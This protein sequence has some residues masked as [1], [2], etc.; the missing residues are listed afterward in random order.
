MSS[1]SS[2][3][4]DGARSYLGMKKNYNSISTP[5]ILNVNNILSGIFTVE[6]NIN[7][8]LPQLVVVGTQSSGKSSLLNGI[9][10]MDIL[11][12]GKNMVTRSPLNIQLFQN[13]ECKVEFGKYANGTWN[14]TKKIPLVGSVVSNL[15]SQRIIQQIEEET[16]KIAGKGKNVSSIP[17][18]LRVFSP[19]VPNLSLVDLPGLTMVACTDQG[20]P[21]DIKEQIT[22]II[23]NY[24]SSERTIILAVMPA[25]S[26]LEADSA[27]ELVKKFDEHG[28]R[29][30]GVLTKIDLMNKD[31]DVIDY[32]MGNI[33]IDLKMKYGYF[34]VRNRTN[35]ETQELSVVGGYKVEDDFFANHEKYGPLT[36]RSRLGVPQLSKNLSEILINHIKQNIPAVLTEIN[37]KYDECY[38]KI[39]EFGNKVPSSSDDKISYL[40]HLVNNYCHEFI[41]SITDKKSS[42]SVGRKLKDVFINY[43][44][45]LAKI[46]PFDSRYCDNEYIL[47]AIKDCE[48]NHMSFP[49]PPIDV[50][51]HCLSDRKVQSFDLLDNPSMKCMDDT[52][53]ILN[54]LISALT[55]TEHIKR[56][57]K[58]RQVLRSSTEHAVINGNMEVCQKKI[59]EMIEMERNYIWTDNDM[60]LLELHEI[61]SQSQKSRAVTPQSMRNILN[62]YFQCV[63]VNIQNN[64]PKAIMMFLIRN[65]TEQITGIFDK[66]SKMD[67]DDLLSEND[68]TSKLRKE[69]EAKLGQLTEAKT[70]INDIN[71]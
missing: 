49:T 24:I 8:K 33:S 21:K 51:E 57:P 19:N 17:I 28:D 37:K 61:M 47:N 52:R 30:I 66:I 12:T 65:T 20:Q 62:S 7:I 39:T 16:I 38:A 59:G 31:S 35:N 6:D 5:E 63:I 69:Y 58:L 71:L 41:R 27:L 15:E 10:G 50:L 14:C 22:G 29:T 40:N 45:E 70:L 32:L 36:D 1:I 64:I 9:M 48:G 34:A 18:I 67:V 56:F 55:G 25:R 11:P 4:M 23:S 44:N 42:T 43:R 53:L 3:L 68:A 54:D 60:F 2:Q 13:S 26:D 46:K